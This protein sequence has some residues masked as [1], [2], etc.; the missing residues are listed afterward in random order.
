[1]FNRKTE[2]EPMTPI[3]YRNF[4]INPIFDYDNGTSDVEYWNTNNEEESGY[5]HEA[6]LWRVKKEIDD[7]IINEQPSHLV[8]TFGPSQS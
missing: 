8:E 1:M 7:K 3:L 5:L 4:Q 2:A 6:T